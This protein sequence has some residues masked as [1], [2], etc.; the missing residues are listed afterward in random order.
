MDRRVFSRFLAGADVAD[1]F[2]LT[3]RAL[4]N[5]DYHINNV[6]NRKLFYDAVGNGVSGAVTFAV[7]KGVSTPNANDFLMT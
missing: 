1:Y 7:L 6:P 2:S 5:E 4:D 3:S